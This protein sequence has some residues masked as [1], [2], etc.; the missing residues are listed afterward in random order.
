[1]PKEGCIPDRTGVGTRLI[2]YWYPQD[3]DKV[4]EDRDPRLDTCLNSGYMV[5]LAPLL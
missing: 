1:M 5:L 2:W 3:F 4:K